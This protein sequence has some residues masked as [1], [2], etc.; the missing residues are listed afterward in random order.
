MINILVKDSGLFYV[1]FIPK[2]ELIGIGLIQKRKS[3]NRTEAARIKSRNR[4]IG[5][6]EVVPLR[7]LKND[8]HLFSSC[9]WILTNR[10]T[11]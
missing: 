10:K 9:D 5:K 4:D 11:I 6:T 8:K 3:I 7:S 1:H 2:N